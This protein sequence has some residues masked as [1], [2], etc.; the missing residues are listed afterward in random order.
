VLLALEAQQIANSADS[1]PATSG[2]VTALRHRIDDAAADLR[3]LVHAVLPSA[4]VERGLTAAAEDLVDRLDIPA[5]LLSDV[6]DRA[7]S[8]ATAQS[9]YLIVAEALTNAVKH[10]QARTVRVEL[11]RAGDQ[12]RVRVS[13]DGRGGARLDRG[14]GLKGLADR[15]D[16]LGGTL[17]LV[18]PEGA[19]T[20]VRVGLP[21]GS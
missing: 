9:A 17:E 13:D 10:S 6:D 11:T 8:P 19:G 18:S 1:D 20:E 14:S 12:L 16:A 4:L 2:A 5:T 21:C 15:V 7:L 3:R